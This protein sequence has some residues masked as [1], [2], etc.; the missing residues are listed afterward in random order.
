M[1]YRALL[2][3]IISILILVLYNYFFPPQKPAVKKHKPASSS[4]QKQE[5]NKPKEEKYVSLLPTSVEKPH[6][7][8]ALG[9][10]IT[11]STPLYQTV[12]YESGA[13][14][15]SFILKKYR[16]DVAPNSP[17]QELICTEPPYLPLGI[18]FLQHKNFAETVKFQADKHTLNLSSQDTPQSLT[19]TAE[20]NG[21]IIKK[22]FIF[23][24]N[25]Y[26]IDF[27]LNLINQ[28]ADFFQDNLAI[29]L[30]NKWPKRER[31]GFYGGIILI[32]GQF[33]EIKWK[34]IKS[35]IVK[36]GKIQWAGLSDKYFT[37]TIVNKDVKK[38]SFIIDRQKELILAKML[39]PP[40]E[41]QPQKRKTISFL[42][43]FGP[44]ELD[45]LKKLGFYLDKAVDFG[46]FD[47]IAKPLLYALK[48]FYKFVHNYGIAIILLTVVIK[49]LF[50]PL[51]HTSYK[52]MQEMQKL[53]P[54]INRLREKYKDDKEKLNKELMNIYKTYKV[55]PLGGCL[56]MILQIPVFFALYKALLYAIELRHANF[57]TYLPFTHKIWLADLSAKDPYYI[58]PILMGISMV[59]QQKMTPSTMGPGQSKYMLLM[60]VFFTFLFLNFPSGLV[61]YWLVNNLLSIVQQFYINRKMQ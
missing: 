29:S 24:P 2:A 47:I 28:T 42:L 22:T 18:D 33:E 36:S 35:Q 13:M 8:I 3:F 48:W 26:K 55:N 1:A 49:I 17:P 41:V 53:Q 6:K 39:L 44:K 32:N 60:P 50:W 61:L 5:K 12:F 14:I 11:V 4:V 34:K 45:R 46:F 31:Y 59:I 30:A 38:A 51:T 19:F 16:Q 23:Y 54:H 27:N 21:I 43:Y 15:K 58:T 56:P 9:K 52:S 20:I 37:T 40:I 25:S 7:S 57:I 10:E